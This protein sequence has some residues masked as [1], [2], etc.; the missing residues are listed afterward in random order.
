MAYGSGI[1][2]VFNAIF[3]QDL[4]LA[5]YINAITI[6]GNNYVL[7]NPLILTSNNLHSTYIDVFL[8]H[9]SIV[10]LFFIYKSYI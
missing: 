4:L 3:E 6:M 9:N 1:H 8:H 2:V 10:W 5:T 7:W